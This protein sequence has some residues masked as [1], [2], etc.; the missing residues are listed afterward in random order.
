MA[1]QPIP[2]GYPRVIPYLTVPDAAAEVE[3]LKRAFGAVEM[4]LMR[5]PDGSIG[6]GELRIG[7]SVVMIG[8]TRGEWQPMP[9]MIYLYTEDADATH[10]RALEAGATLVAP[11]ADQFYGDRHGAVKDPAGNVWYIATHVEDVS[12]DEMARRHEAYVKAQSKG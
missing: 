10:A 5:G 4:F 9:C 11:L 7:D 3:F 12:P 6:H 1:V 2:D 8:Q